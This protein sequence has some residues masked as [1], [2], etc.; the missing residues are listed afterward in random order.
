MLAWVRALQRALTVSQSRALRSW[1][2]LSVVLPLL[3]VDWSLGTMVTVTWQQQAETVSRTVPREEVAGLPG[4]HHHLQSRHPRLKNPHRPLR[5]FWARVRERR[6]S[7]AQDPPAEHICVDV[8]DYT[9]RARN[10]WQSTK[11]TAARKN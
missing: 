6:K 1:A 4:H 11:E 3:G 2:S 8:S 9:V 7:T 10:I 5:R